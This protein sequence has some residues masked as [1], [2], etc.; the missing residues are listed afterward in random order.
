[1]RVLIVLREEV[2]KETEAEVEKQ[3]NRE[4]ISL[5]ESVQKTADEDE[6]FVLEETEWAPKKKKKTRQTTKRGN[7][8]VTAVLVRHIYHYRVRQMRNCNSIKSRLTTDKSGQSSSFGQKSYIHC[9]FFI[10]YSNVSRL[11]IY[12]F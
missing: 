11:I 4:T 1:M 12:C 3:R 9:V 6:E 8:S 10:A 7:F 2:E 5:A